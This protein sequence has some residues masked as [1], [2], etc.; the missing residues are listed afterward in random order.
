MQTIEEKRSFLFAT[1][2]RFS[3]EVQPVRETAIDKI[4]EQNLLLA[5]QGLS[6]SGIVQQAASL[7]DVTVITARD[8]KDSLGRLLVRGRVVAIETT[9]DGGCFALLDTVRVQLWQIQQEAENRFSK[10]CER[11]FKDAPRP[12]DHYAVAFRDCLCAIFSRL[13][14]AYVRVLKGD[15]RISDFV[16]PHTIDDAVSGSAC[17]VSVFTREHIRTAL[18]SFFEENDPDYASIKWNLAQNYYVAKALGL[19]PTGALLSREVFAGAVFYLDTNV[20]IPAIESKARDHHSAKMLLSACKQIG[21]EVRACQISVQQL[22]NLTQYNANIVSKVADQI[23][24]QTIPKVRNIFYTLYRDQLTEA[25]SFDPDTAFARFYKPS[26]LFP[27]IGVELCDDPWFVD[28]DANVEICAAAEALNASLEARNRRPKRR[29][30]ALHDAALVRWVEKERA[31][32]NENTW[33]ITLDSSL[34]DTTWASGSEK[35]I[36]IT[37][38]ALLQWL[39][40]I[41]VSTN[42]DFERSYSE[43][44]KNLLLPQEN[45]FDLRDFLI[46]AEIDWSCKELPASDVEGCIRS[47]RRELPSVDPTRPEGRE[48]LSHHISKFFTDPS[49]KFK[50]EVERLERKNRDEAALF[51]ELLTDAEVAE[52]ERLA[53]KDAQITERD[54][55]IES[56]QRQITEVDHGAQEALLHAE[57]QLDA[58]RTSRENEAL[59]RSALFRL[60]L[61]ISFVLVMEVFIASA[62][63][64][65]GEGAGWLKRITG[66]WAILASAGCSVFPISWLFVGK[67]RLRALGWPFTKLLRVEGCD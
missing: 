8:V 15:N 2:L 19:D 38:D 57:E 59:R 46:F 9:D 6:F 29:N 10:V 37:L 14:E 13:G 3:P 63:I 21:I 31:S 18:L 39:S 5:E 56:L 11:L 50:Q 67:K 62:Y 51:T 30:S 36:A 45:F 32:G 48:R 44:V 27:E 58:E 7:G 28:I 55:T 34:S 24:E 49:R 26:D 20:I 35:P 65:F 25:G 40:P 23:P 33:L 1:R 22:R 64:R 54:L 16:G 17:T 42:G 66:G 43:A 4:M 41:V 61:C 60:A 53:E 12:R 52:R 47:I